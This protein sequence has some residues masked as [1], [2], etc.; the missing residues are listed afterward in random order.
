ML[1][2][3][4]VFGVTYLATLAIAWRWLLLVFGGKAASFGAESRV[5]EV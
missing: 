5:F 2:A 3:A 4:I 1:T